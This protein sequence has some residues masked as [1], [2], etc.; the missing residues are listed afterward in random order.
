MR[1]LFTYG[2]LM[3]G[4]ERNHVL[5]EHNGEYLGGSYKTG[6]LYNINNLYPAFMFSSGSNQDEKD[7]VYV[8]GEVWG[9]HKVDW[10]E[11]LPRLDQIEGHPWLFRRETM[12]VRIQIDEEDQLVDAMTYM[13]RH[14]DFRTQPLIKS[15]RWTDIKEPVT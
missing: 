14:P 2:T 7:I 6:L 5:Q 8:H 4:Q 11:L 9:F 10:N 1:Y 12:L 15:G 3:T 13:G